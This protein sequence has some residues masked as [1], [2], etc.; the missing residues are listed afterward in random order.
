M[1]YGVCKNCGYVGMV[2]KHHVFFKSK[3]RALKS[4]ELNLVDLCTYCHRGINGVHGKHGHKLDIKLKRETQTKIFQI[5]RINK[6]DPIK[7]EVVY[8]E[9]S[10][11]LKIPFE[12]TCKVLKNVNVQWGRYKI[13]DVVRALQGGRL[14]E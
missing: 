14:I 7:D 3:A 12:E 5:L 11:I 8:S 10:E 1:H 4:C 9:P 6:L 13:E 2:E